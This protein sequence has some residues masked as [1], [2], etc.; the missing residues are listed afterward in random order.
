MKKT[1]SLLLALVMIVSVFAACG[2]KPETAENG[3]DTAQSVDAPAP[4]TDPD[5]E[6]SD[7]EATETVTETGEVTIP[8][9]NT[10]TPA[11]ETPAPQGQAPSQTPQTQTPA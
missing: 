11:D 8:P 10:Q 1:L 5:D 6:E 9:A 7:K 2:E 4:V 3:A